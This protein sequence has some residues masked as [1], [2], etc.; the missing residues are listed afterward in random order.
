MTLLF[1]GKCNLSQLLLFPA[2]YN[3]CKCEQI[4][5]ALIFLLKADFNQCFKV[6]CYVFIGMFIFNST[7]FLVFVAKRK[8][9]KINVRLPVLSYWYLAMVVYGE[10][11]I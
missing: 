11:V 9:F 1:K 6:N 4:N 7:G 10:I 5:A 8:N 3:F 2:T